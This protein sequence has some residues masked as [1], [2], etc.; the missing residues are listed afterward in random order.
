MTKTPKFTP[1]A[2]RSSLPRGFAKM[3]CEML[4]DSVTDRMVYSVI[5][6]ATQNAKITEKLI[7]LAE[8]NLAR[9]NA[10]KKRL[11]E[12]VRLYQPNQESL[13]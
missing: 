4:N 1:F 3:V 8:S 6:G 12:V 10:N 5:S 7:E 13:F 2:L 9:I 11:I